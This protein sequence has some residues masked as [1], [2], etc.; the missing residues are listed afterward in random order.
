[1]LRCITLIL[2][3]LVLNRWLMVGCYIHGY[4]QGIISDSGVIGR[5][6]GLLIRRKR[7]QMDA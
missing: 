6:R 3:N 2:L 1:M 5:R 7:G 4:G